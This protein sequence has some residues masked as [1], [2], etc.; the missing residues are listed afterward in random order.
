MHGVLY[1]E[2][3]ARVSVH[4]CI[5]VP[6]VRGARK[7]AKVVIV[8]MLAWL[9]PRFCHLHPI[10]NSEDL[11]SLERHNRV[12]R[13][14]PSPLLQIRQDIELMSVFFARIIHV[15]PPSKLVRIAYVMMCHI[16]L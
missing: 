15:A 7:A 5:I 3:S 4:T 9:A 6:F 11:R 10:V 2:R 1:I 16:R 12:E 8:I 13:R 14:P